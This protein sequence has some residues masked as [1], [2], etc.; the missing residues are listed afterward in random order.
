MPAGYVTQLGTV[1][2]QTYSYVDEMVVSVTNSELT[3]N[4]FGGGTL[5]VCLC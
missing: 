3:H 4:P 2:V 1:F 5:W